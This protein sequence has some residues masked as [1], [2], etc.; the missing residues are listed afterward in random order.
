L[1]FQRARREA[2][3]YQEQ[4][5]S[6]HIENLNRYLRIASPL[7]PRDPALGHFRIRHPDL[8]PSNII[9]SGS[10]DSNLHVVG[11]IDWQH[12]SILPSFLLAGIPQR[13]QNYNDPVSQS[14]TRLPQP[15]NLHDLDEP[16]QSKEMEP[17]RR[18][19]FLHHYVE[20]TEKYNK[21]H[22]TALTDPMRT[23]RCRLFNHASDPW[24][25]ETLALKVALI[26]ATEDWG[27]L[28]GGDPPCPIVFDLEDVRET[29][30]LDAEQT[31]MDE[32][33]QACRNLVGCGPEGWTSVERYEEVMT[34]SKRL[35]EDALA[36]AESEEE[37]A[38]IA[39][40]WPFDDMDEK[41]YM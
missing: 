10:P 40:H 19:L 17:Y 16:Q 23:L 4:Q 12:T 6:D 30:K 11:L 9:V 35:K 20:N 31:G 14:M 32:T 37:R 1:P 7:I 25:G 27:T 13:L 34:L 21:L 36:V 3:Q 26:Q 5:P 18:L 24:E 2:Y 38:Q 29:M 15:E 39:A 8:Q 41:E 22:H 28:T 33:L